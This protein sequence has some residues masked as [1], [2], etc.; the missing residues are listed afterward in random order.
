MTDDVSDI[1]VFYD[2]DPEREHHRL[3]QHQ[4]EYDLTWRYLKH[5]CPLRGLFWKLA[6]QPDD[7]PWKWLGAGTG[8]QRLICRRG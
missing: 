4:L 3:E 8:S 7:T 5:I 6:R 1:G 2:S